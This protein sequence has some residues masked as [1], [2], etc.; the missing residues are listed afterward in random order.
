M[1]LNQRPFPDF[2]DECYRTFWNLPDLEAPPPKAEYAAHL[3]LIPLFTD[4]YRR[5]ENL[6]AFIRAAIYAR[7]SCLLN[8]DAVAQNV[9]VKLYIEDV[10]REAFDQTLRTNFV[11]PEED[12]IWFHAPP[13]EKTRDGIYGHLG[14]QMF[15]F[16]DERFAQ[17]KRVTVWD[18]DMFWL[19]ACREH[20]VFER[21]AALPSDE[22]G[23]AFAY[24]VQ[25]KYL[26]IH[27]DFHLIAD[28]KH[29]GI[30]RKELLKMADVPRFKG[31]VFFPMGCFWS[32]PAR[33]FH[34]HH[35]DFV[36][37]MQTY[38]PYFGND[39][40]M[41]TCWNAKFGIPLFP[42]DRHLNV[43]LV[44]MERLIKNP[45]QAH[46]YHGLID[47][48]DETVFRKQLRIC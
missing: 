9:S 10:L 6:A 45:A 15:A 14:K 17:F 13:L 26:K 38:A 46:L 23:Y 36:N 18:A 42:L 12:V 35:P 24:P 22:I 43:R 28:T 8:T 11:D 20:G 16:W 29:G 33:H 44:T 5:V 31:D 27:W 25:W 3:C 19:A 21:F 47:T 40:I 1:R 41:A 39:Q 30:S 7:A 32:Y 34:Q 2:I 48:A 37:W 4:A